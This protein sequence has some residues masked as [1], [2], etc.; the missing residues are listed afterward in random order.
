MPAAF[1]KLDKILRLEQSQGYRNRAVIGGLEKFAELWQD[2]AQAEDL[3]QVQS[4]QA[5]EIGDL[6]K[7]YAPTRSNWT[8]LGSTTSFSSAQARL[9]NYQGT[10][11]PDTGP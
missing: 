3:D 2:E 9:G 5:N 7:L 4:E 10:Q 6:L 8:D 1:D 11:C